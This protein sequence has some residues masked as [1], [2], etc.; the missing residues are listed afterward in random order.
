[1]LYILHR[2]IT[3]TCKNNNGVS[4]EEER[5]SLRRKTSTLSQTSSVQ[6]FPLV[7]IPTIRTQTFPSVTIPTALTSTISFSVR[8]S[9]KYS[10]FYA[11]EVN[12]TAD[13]FFGTNLCSY[14]VFLH[15]AIPP[16][17]TF[18]QLSRI[19]NKLF[20]YLNIS[21]YILNTFDSETN[22]FKCYI[23]NKQ[24]ITNTNEYDPPAST[25]SVIPS[26]TAAGNASGTSST[27]KPRLS[28]GVIAGIAIAV[29]GIF[30]PPHF[31]S[32]SQ[33]LQIDRS[34]SRYSNLRTF[35]F[36][37]LE[38]IPQ[39]EQDFFGPLELTL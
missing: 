13:S 18:H 23:F 33:E 1:M 36:L 4:C 16:N 30:P 14:L 24:F 2:G 32:P 8:P 37:L 28:P 5:L 12:R 21:S 17:N 9:Q 27:P 39:P 22:R 19:F 26:A 15:L 7:T 25:S 34:C 29:F 10:G 3:D 38:T 31:P 11:D 35:H 6:T 20:L